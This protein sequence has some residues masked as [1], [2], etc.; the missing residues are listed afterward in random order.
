M[1]YL[2]AVLLSVL[3]CLSVNAQDFSYFNKNV[4]ETNEKCPIDMGNGM[5]LQSV[6]IDNAAKT[7]TMNYLI[8]KS[9][10]LESLKEHSDI[11]HDAMAA[12]LSTDQAQA[13]LRNACLKA[14]VKI[15]NVLSD[16]KNVFSIIITPD[17]LK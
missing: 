2:Y 4:V 6:A 9:I 13:D 1:K 5:I 10:S 17:D 15:V 16:G 12:D 14:G 3:M 8:D 11:L 7:Y